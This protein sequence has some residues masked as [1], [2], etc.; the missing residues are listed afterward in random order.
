MTAEQRLERDLPSILDEIVMGPY[1]DYI[2]DVLSTTARGRQRPGWA[3]P[4]RWLPV[5][6]ATTR[7]PTTRLPWRQLGVL[8]L[9]AVLLGTMIAVYVGTRTPK[10]PAPFGPAD[11]GLVGLQRNGDL[12]VVD[13][14]TGQESLLV[15]GPE[16]DDWVDFTPDGTR[17]VFIRWGPENGGLTVAKI[18]SV[19]IKGGAPTFI[20][21]DVIH[22]DSWIQTAPNGRDVAF[23]AYDYNSPVLRIHVAALDG[24]SYHQFS[25]VQITDYGALNYLAPDGREIVYLARSLNQQTHDIRA[26]DV[27][28]GQTRAIL[29]TSIGADV[30]GNVAASPDGKHLAYSSMSATGGATVHVIGTDGQDDRMVGH[31]TGATFEGWPQWDPQGRRLLIERDAGDGIARPVVID[32]GGGADVTIDTTI[33]SGGAGKMWAPDGTAILAQRTTQ[34]GR[35]LQEEIWN[36]R[37]GEVTQVSWPS[38]T[39]PVWQRTAH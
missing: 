17:A 19:P 6:I 7:V 2:E 11:N 39:P 32:L 24:S 9:L 14:Q 21:K 37:T 33:S 30:F 15:G 28:T 8:A 1:P 5:E 29:E 27:D 25:D 12:Y 26:L 31:M 38:V 23:T 35:Q 3:F 13:P 18:G 16:Q 20:E 34:D 22:S 10:I 36:V 4:E